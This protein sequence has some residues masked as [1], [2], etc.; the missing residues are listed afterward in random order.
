M[1]WHLHNGDC[2]AMMAAMPA[3]SADSVVCDP[4]YGL[5]FMGKEFDKIGNG[6]AQQAWHARWLVE[7]L[8]VLKPGGHLV[9]FGGQ[10]T[11]HRLTCA[12]EDVGFEVRDQG[13]W[14]TYTGF[15]KSLN[16]SVALDKMAGA[17]REVVGRK[18]D[19]M[20][21]AQVS[22]S[23]ASPIGLGTSAQDGAWE[24]AGNI[25]TPT[26]EAAKKWN[27]YGT[28]LKPALE[29]W[30]MCRKPL[31]G[32]VAANVLQWGTGALNIDAARYGYG[33]RAWPGP[34]TQ[35][36]VAPKSDP[37]RRAGVVGSDL[38]ISRSSASAMRDAQAESIA[39]TLDLGRWPANVYHCP[40]TSRAEREAGCHH[41]PARTGAEAV[42]RDED[43]AG[44]KSARAGANDI[45]NHHPTLKP[46]ALMS[47]L[48]RLVTPTGGVILDPFAGSGS[49]GAA[50]VPQGFR[51]IGA[52]LEADYALIAEAR[53]SHHAGLFGIRRPDIASVL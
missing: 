38:G 39:R 18:A 21:A 30:V 53:I 17:E 4:P 32:T 8:R 10:R 37:A 45:H 49:C 11:I 13:A 34:M 41:L 19:P 36:L 47:W 14:L 5:G 51:Y 42:D 12:A 52:E 29:P 50:A 24:R 23:S 27:G 26:T 48:C 7:A 3:D 31:N 25:T 6:A 43:S 20:Y 46:I 33:D 35:D 28:A 15:P 40:K 1:K 9:A 44:I 22:A 16:V 2:V